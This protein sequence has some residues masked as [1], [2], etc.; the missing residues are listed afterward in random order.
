[1]DAIEFVRKF[2][3][4]EARSVLLKSKYH[5]EVDVYLVDT[6]EFTYIAIQ[7]SE[8][9]PFVSLT[10]L[11]QIVEAFEFIEKEFESVE[12]A[13][14]EYMVSGC[15]SDPFWIKAKQSIELLEKC[16]A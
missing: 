7:P 13:Y 3:S 5:Y 9:D 16:N 14:Y 11:K 1:M 8:N 2:G 6:K 10:D 12:I 4:C 15:Y